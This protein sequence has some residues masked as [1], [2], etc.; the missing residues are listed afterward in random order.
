MDNSVFQNLLSKIQD[1]RKL[2]DRH[3]QHMEWFREHWN[4]ALP[5]LFAEIY[6]IRQIDTNDSMAIHNGV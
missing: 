6:D 1:L 2:G 3:M 5:P 4:R